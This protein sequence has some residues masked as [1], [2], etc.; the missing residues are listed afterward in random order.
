MLTHTRSSKGGLNTS[1]N[2]FPPWC[3]PE[4][5]GHQ[6]GLCLTGGAASRSSLCAQ[7]GVCSAPAHRLL[8]YV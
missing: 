4:E 8:I 1:E 7:R 5:Q 6:D 2:D 3:I